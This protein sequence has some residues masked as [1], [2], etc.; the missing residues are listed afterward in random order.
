[1]LLV[2]LIEIGVNLFD[3]LLRAAHGQ[4]TVSAE[5]VVHNE[6]QRQQVEERG[7]VMAQE[8]LFFFVSTDL[9]Q[10]GN[11]HCDAARVSLPDAAALSASTYRRSSGSVPERRRSIHEPSSKINFAPSV[12]LIDMTFRPAS[13]EASTAT[14]LPAFAFCSSER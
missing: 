5:N 2:Q 14:R 8:R 12:R 3:F 10:F 1:I 4:I 9:V 11:S 13:V 7:P 6:D